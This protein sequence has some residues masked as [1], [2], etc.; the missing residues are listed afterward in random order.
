[1]AVT[2]ADSRAAALAALVA[3]AVGAEPFDLADERR[4]LY[5]AAA[6][7]ASNYLVTLASIAEDLFAR[8]GLPVDSALPAFL[9]LMQGA[10][11]NMRA[12][13][14]VAALTGPLSRGDVATVAAHLDA[15]VRQAPDDLAIYGALGRATLPLLR[16]RGEL[17]AATIGALDHLLVSTTGTSHDRDL[18]ADHQAHDCERPAREEVP[19][20]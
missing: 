20:P 10:L 7:V 19:V 16:A 4:V 11:D 18:P 12:H 14:T 15:L 2:A 3:V 9:P 6:V 1:M 5:H 17:S 8:A 13:G